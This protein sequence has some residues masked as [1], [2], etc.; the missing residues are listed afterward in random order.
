MKSQSVTAENVRSL[1]VYDPETGAMSLISGLGRRTGTKD[2]YLRITIHGCTFP[3]HRLA[4]LYM[5][6]EWPLHHIDHRD[7][8]RRNNKWSN[9][10][11]ATPAEN[12]MNQVAH[13]D[14]TSGFKGVTSNPN[15]KANPWRAYIGRSGG[16]RYLGSFPTAEQ[17]H[18]KYLEEATRR[19]GE[20]A[21]GN[22]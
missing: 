2:K 18:E 22:K 15:S 19:F 3:V 17:A 4:W 8:D 14:N 11:Q 7:R 1:I 13:R 5:T 6:G 10:R 9:L 16:K 21:R 12:S 20:Y